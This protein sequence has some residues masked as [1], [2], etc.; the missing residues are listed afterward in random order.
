MAKLPSLQKTLEA[1]LANLAT[2]REPSTMAAYRRTVKQFLR[3]L[4]ANYPDTNAVPALRRDPHVVGW[5]RSLC[6]RNPPL[7]NATRRFHIGI[8]RQVF[9]TI[10]LTDEHS[11]QEDLILPSDFPPLNHY[12]PNPL[13]PEDDALLQQHL[14]NKDDLPSNALLLLRAS[15]MRIGELLNLPINCL[16][17][18][19]SDRWALHVPL[20]KLHTERLVPIDDEIRRIHARILLLRR[21]LKAKRSPF[22]IPQRRSRRS[23]YPHKALRTFLAKSAQD[24]G[25][26]APV[27]PHQLR[28][29][30]ATEMLRA[31]VSLPAVMQL[32]GHKNIQMTL[33]YIQVNQTD[34][35]RQYHTARRTIATLHSI[36]TLLLPDPQSGSAIQAIT[37]SLAATRHL[38]EMYRRHLGEHSVSRRLQRLENRLSKIASDLQLFA[39]DALK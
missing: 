6:E 34:L 19:D 12:L 9:N 10:A 25:C 18:L 27:T 31:G 7:A 16:R 8:L 30:Y 35:Q 21:P 32:L 28:H 29:T 13:S 2:T 14:R 26:S 4:R 33:R 22:L 20:G 23:L 1:Q 38:L 15:G 24:A 5:L 39:Q 37:N 36:P 3:F 11:F 17:H